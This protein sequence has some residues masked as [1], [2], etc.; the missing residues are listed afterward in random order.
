[1]L[2]NNFILTQKKERNNLLIKT[3]CVPISNHPNRAQQKHHE[4][5]IRHQE[6]SLH[7]YNVYTPEAH[8]MFLCLGNI[9]PLVYMHTLG[10]YNNDDYILKNL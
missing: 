6:L 1:M 8:T 2:M 4:N 3:W 9:F 7:I 5:Q 10:Q